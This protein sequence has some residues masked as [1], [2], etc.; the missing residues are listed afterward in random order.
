M[1][2]FLELARKERALGSRTLLDVLNGETSLL[3]AQSDA[4]SAEIDVLLSGYAVLQSVGQLSE[5]AVSP[6]K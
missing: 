1:A 2:R 3:N 6:S 5:A 4:I